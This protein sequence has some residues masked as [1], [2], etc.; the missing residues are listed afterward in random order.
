MPAEEFLGHLGAAGR[1]ALLAGLA[2]RRYARGETVIAQTE[3]STDVFF[4]LAGLARATLYSP[5]GR[6]VAYRDIPEGAIFGE[7]AAID[8]GRRSATVTAVAELTVGRLSLPEFRRLVET[9]PEF[10]WALLRYFCA[11]MRRLSERVYEFSTM[12]IRERLIHELV[13][14]AEPHARPDGSAELRPA[15]THF[16]LA[17][18]ISTHREAVSREMSRLAKLGLIARRGRGLVVPDIAALRAS[19]GERERG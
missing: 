16:E 17:T 9:E 14:V 19:S 15:P 10:T 6:M 3:D 4:V 7:I 1:A 5:D 12:H 11:Q 13:R 18:R 8:G 2:R